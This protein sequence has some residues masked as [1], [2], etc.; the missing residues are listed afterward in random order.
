MKCKSTD[1]S[2]FGKGKRLGENMYKK[3]HIRHFFTKKYMT[4]NLKK[5]R[6]I[7]VRKTSSVYHEYKS[8][9]I[10]AAAEKI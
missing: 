9:F 2:L 3:S 10:E 8:A 4:E 5:F 6:I 1:D 7:K